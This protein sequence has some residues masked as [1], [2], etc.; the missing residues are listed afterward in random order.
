MSEV[1][2]GRRSF[3][4]RTAAAAA[5]VGSMK[6]AAQSSEAKTDM[7]TIK[8]ALQLGNLPG[9]L[10]DSEKFKLAKACGWDGIEAYPMDDLEAA[11]K[12]GETARAAGV[13]IHSTCFGGWKTPFSSPDAAIIDKGLAAME[14]ALRS[15]KAMGGEVVL[16]VPAVVNAAVSYADAY[17]RSQEHIRKLLPVAKEVGVIIAVENVWNRFLLSP[18]EFARYLDEFDSPWLRAYFDVG[19][20]VAYGWPEHWIRTLGERIARVHLKDFKGTGGHCGDWKPLREGSV[21]WPEVRRAFDDIGYTGWMTTEVGG[22][23]EAFL[24]DLAHRVDLIIA[25]Q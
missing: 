12:L 6:A 19:N 13:R 1:S 11:A 7:P 14:V 24:R 17:A 5:V 21:N 22:G 16:L 8:K 9:K 23:D 20:V 18:L 3:L 2:I 25:G 15:T 4:K 10:S